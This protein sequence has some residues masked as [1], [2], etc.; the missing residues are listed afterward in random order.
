[1]WEDRNEITISSSNNAT[2]HWMSNLEVFT[3][4]STLREEAVEF[5]K[6]NVDTIVRV[7]VFDNFSL[8]YGRLL[9]NVILMNRYSVL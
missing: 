1:M 9:C 4:V 6:A 2:K 8:L 5:I 7:S 3:S